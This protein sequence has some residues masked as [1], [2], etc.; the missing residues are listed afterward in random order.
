[1]GFP[2]V[3]FKVK[4]KDGTRAQNSGGGDLGLVSRQFNLTTTEF[5]VWSLFDGRA[6][7]TDPKWDAIKDFWVEQGQI[8][9]VVVNNPAPIPSKVYMYLYEGDGTIRQFEEVPYDGSLE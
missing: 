4:L 5:T 8:A 6:K 1:M 7:I 3:P 2:D 9:S